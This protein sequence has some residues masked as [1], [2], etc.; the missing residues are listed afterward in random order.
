MGTFPAALPQ[1]ITFRAIDAALSLLSSLSLLVASISLTR[2]HFGLRCL[3]HIL[4]ERAS[5]IIRLLELTLP[6]AAYITFISACIYQLPFAGS[7]LAWHFTL[8]DVQPQIQFEL[9]VVV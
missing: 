8:L 6:I 1:A 4:S 2:F 9:P 7:V 5:L 3:L